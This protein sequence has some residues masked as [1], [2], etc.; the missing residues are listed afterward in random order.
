MTHSNW[1]FPEDDPEVT[2]G[3]LSILQTLL[4]DSYT[5]NA[6]QSDEIAELKQKI[7]TLKWDVQEARNRYND[8][9]KELRFSY[10]EDYE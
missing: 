1:E 2:K 7:S 3:A 9:V 8:L 4:D 5:K 10:T 6:K